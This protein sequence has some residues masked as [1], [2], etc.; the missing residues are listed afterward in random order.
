MQS[1][2]TDKAKAALSCAEKSAKS[3]QAELTIGWR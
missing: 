3:Y 2:Y 1:H